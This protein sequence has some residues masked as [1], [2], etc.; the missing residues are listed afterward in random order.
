VK[1]SHQVIA[2]KAEIIRFVAKAAVAEQLLP[3]CMAGV[4]E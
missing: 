1:S 4:K 2:I 3:M